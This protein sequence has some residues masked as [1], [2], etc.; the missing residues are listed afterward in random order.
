M[1]NANISELPIGAKL[2]TATTGK[3]IQVLKKL[4]EGGQG[5]VY[6]VNYNGEQKALKW[7]KTTFIK[8]S[9]SPTKFYKNIESNISK[10]SPSREFLWPKD[11]TGW[12]NGTF[13][14]IMDVRPGGYYDISDYL[15][16]RVTIKNFK[17]LCDAALHIISAF[18][19]LHL[20]GYAYQDLNDGNFFINPNNGDV[21]ICDND[22]V[23]PNGTNSGIIGKPRFIAPEVVLGQTMPTNFSDRFSMALILFMLMCHVHPF[24]GKRSLGIATPEMQKALYGTGALFVMDKTDRSNCC[25]QRVHAGALMLWPLMPEYIKE[26]FYRSFTKGQGL[27][28][29]MKRPSEFEWL[30]AVARFRSDLVDCPKCGEEIFLS[31]GNT[32]VCDN[33][34]CNYNLSVPFKIDNGRY[35]IPGLPGSRIYRCNIEMCKPE[36]ALTPV[37]MVIA[38]PKNPRQFGLKNL[39]STIWGA[40]TPSGVKKSVPPKEIVPLV[41][42]IVIE[43]GRENLKFT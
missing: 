4:G 10:G 34:R 28:I 15:L 8:N 35:T 18:Y 2:T 22:N 16:N 3:T 25:D 43:I 11:I 29:V 42:G 40:T 30:E 36:D 19:K 37:A 12:S 39:S 27:D 9:P 21:L 7:Y 6:L 5:I 33:R 20:K 13:G 41:K 23:A 1:S 32:T 24:E 38:N 17:T 26:L 31:G 14:Y